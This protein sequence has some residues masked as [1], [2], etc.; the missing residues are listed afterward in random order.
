MR[1]PSAIAGRT[2]PRKRRLRLVP[3]VALALG[4]T[5]C[6]GMPTNVKRQVV[7]P[8]EVPIQLGTPARDNLTPLEAPLAC[9]ARE[10]A[11][12]GRPP[13]V[14]G[15]GEVKDFT[16][17]YSI[18][19]GNAVTQGGSLMLYSALGKMGGAVRI[20]ERYDPSIAERE[21]GYMD[22][23]QL[24][25]GQPHDANGQRVPWLPYFGGTVQASDYYIVGGI[26][27]VNYNIASGGGEFALNNI[28][29]KGRTYSQSVAIDLRIVDTRSLLVVDAI[30]LSK[31]FVGY[32][33][34]ANTFRFFGIGLVNV[35]VG[36]KGQEPLQ[37]GI[38]ATIEEA[39]IRLIA[40][41]GGVDPTKC[42]ALRGQ[43]ISTKSSEA[44]FAD[45]AK[46]QAPALASPANRGGGKAPQPKQPA[47]ALPGPGFSL[48]D[49]R[50]QAA[51]PAAKPKVAPPAQPQ[52]GKPGMAPAPAAASP[53]RP[54]VAPKP[55]A[56]VQP[57][58]PKQV[59][60]V[61]LAAPK[62]V[63]AA[64]RQASLPP[65]QAPQQA[66]PKPAMA[67]AVAPAPAQAAKATV[68]KAPAQAPAPA[69]TVRPVASP[70]AAQPV[71][72]KP[73]APVSA[74]AVPARPA[75]VQA[76][77]LPAPVQPAQPVN[78]KPQPI[79]ENKSSAQPATRF[80]LIF[81]LGSPNLP[82]SALVMLDS[83]AAA[84]RQGNPVSIVLLSP[85]SEKF[86]P[87]QRSRLLDQRIAS[88]VLALA[89][90]GVPAGVV[91]VDWRPANTESTI[92]RE[93]PGVQLIAKIRLMR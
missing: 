15:V 83:A 8:G 25:D 90:R 56:P 16:G 61:P 3:I 21:L 45:M 36:S 54:P 51:A 80:I 4:T 28:G 69:A 53:A 60:T 87:S 85:E 89:A 19:E 41:A 11:A 44:I 73:A 33:V 57:V 10:L 29:F 68:A 52:A 5:A 81:E 7:A 17:R 88:L 86:E 93:G 26:T 20:A 79:N 82:A 72:A 62:P 14:V 84:V 65:P 24:G 76:A 75:P 13:I 18:N 47:A 34:G 48:L 78:A 43:E 91:S 63:A 12:A 30:S 49:E 66:A 23:R 67:Q 6:A 38:R 70:A 46:P 1:K 74:P 59:A 32:E 31:Q 22:R 40:R 55:A 50:K 9:F 39:A 71:A 77:A 37:L 2:A 92:Y 27:E 35:N 64:S 42:L 58:A